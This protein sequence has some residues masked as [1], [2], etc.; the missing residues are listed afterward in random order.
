M[1]GMYLAE[2]RLYNSNNKFFQAEN[3]TRKEHAISTKKLIFG[4]NAF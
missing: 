2:K 1:K 4:N 3:G